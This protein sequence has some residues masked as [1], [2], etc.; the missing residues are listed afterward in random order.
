MLAP[1][2][3]YSSSWRTHSDNSAAGRSRA[4]RAP[5]IEGHEH[6]V[7]GEVTGW[8]VR[9]RAAPIVRR[10][11]SSGLRA[12]MPRLWRVKALRSDG[13][14]VLNVAA[15]ALTLPSRSARA[16]ARS[17]SAGRPGIGWAASPPAAP[18][19][20]APS[21]RRRPSGRRGGCRAGGRPAAADLAGE[22]VGLWLRPSGEHL[23]GDQP[24]TS[25][26]SRIDA[27]QRVAQG[28]VDPRGSWGP[29]GRPAR[30]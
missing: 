22:L 9:W 2:M 13:Q 14:V 21:G 24:L 16:K 29:V 6:R 23:G 7:E 18:A 12:G 11:T 27:Y 5:G 26:T 28:L 4:R 15:A 1:R 20:A 19:W 17:A 8:L 3:A 30:C 25:A 10:R